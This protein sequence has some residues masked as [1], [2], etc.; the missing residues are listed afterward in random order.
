MTANTALLAAVALLAAAQSAVQAA[1][2]I[3]PVLTAN[4]YQ[5]R[6]G[7][8]I[9]PVL[10]ANQY[11]TQA[12]AV[13]DGPESD[14]DCSAAPNASFEY[15]FEIC[16]D[17][18][19]MWWVNGACNNGVKEEMSE[20]HKC[21]TIT[22]DGVELGDRLYC[23]H[24]VDYGSGRRMTLC[25]ADEENKDA[26]CGRAFSDNAVGCGTQKMTTYEHMCKADSGPGVSLYDR[27]EY[28][29]EEGMV[30]NNPVE[31]TCGKGWYYPFDTGAEVVFNQENRYCLNCGSVG[32][33][34]RNQGATCEKLGVKDPV[35]KNEGRYVLL[36]NEVAAKSGG[37]RREIDRVGKVAALM[38]VAAS[39]IFAV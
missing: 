17:S 7:S 31:H 9:G 36:P 8:I 12:S 30:Y 39:L 20:L 25:G 3:G 35:P 6:A 37:G 28:W 13:S 2:T 5:R 21:A 11:Q 14:I 16:H 24:C 29:C 15:Y 32:I 26:A 10:T 38:A 18:R 27:Q 22:G 34:A 23:H 4:Q 1:S 33:C 19:H